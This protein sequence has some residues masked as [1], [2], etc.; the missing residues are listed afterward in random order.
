MFVGFKESQFSSEVFIVCSSSY[1]GDL[2]GKSESE[3]QNQYPEIF[4]VPIYSRIAVHCK[5]ENPPASSLIAPE[6]SARGVPRS[7]VKEEPGRKTGRG[8]EPGHKQSGGLFVPSE[9]PGLW[10][11]AACK[12]GG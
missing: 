11:G 1:A 9:G 4:Q 3:L 8:R 12:A 6:F 7:E 2:N 5:M 10:P